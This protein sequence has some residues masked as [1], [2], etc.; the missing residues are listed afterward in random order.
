MNNAINLGLNDFIDKIQPK[1]NVLGN[2]II[3]DTVKAFVT[4]ISELKE[5]LEDDKMSI[6]EWWNKRDDARTFLNIISRYKDF[7]EDALALATDEDYQAIVIATLLDGIDGFIENAIDLEIIEHYVK[8]VYHG[9]IASSKL[10]NRV[11]EG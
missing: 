7:E 2:Q 3:A 11:K 6:G 4:M 9:V 5:D 1:E 10:V 8:M